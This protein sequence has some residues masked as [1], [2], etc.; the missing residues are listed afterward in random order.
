MDNYKHNIQD[1]SSSYFSSSNFTPNYTNKNINQQ[2]PKN[3]LTQE[4][5]KN[6][7]S[8]NN[9]TNN[10]QTVD[11]IPILTSN[12]IV[13]SSTQQMNTKDL[14]P[15]NIDSIEYTKKSISDL[16]QKKNQIKMLDDASSNISRAEQARTVNPVTTSNQITNNVSNVSNVL[17]DYIKNI[18]ADYSR[19]P[20]WK[21]DVG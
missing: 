3:I 21:T 18:K 14:K 4:N 13:A 16:D 15:K 12:K 9:L 2:T 20:Q 6:F 11:D 17:T 10:K 1:N 19:L 5:V 8:E 7:I